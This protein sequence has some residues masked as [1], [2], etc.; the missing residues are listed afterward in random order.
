MC[1][2]NNY[3]QRS[4]LQS[5]YI[6]GFQIHNDHSWPFKDKARTLGINHWRQIAGYM[7]GLCLPIDIEVW[8]PCYLTNKMVKRFDFVVAFRICRPEPSI[9]LILG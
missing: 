5:A 3:K 9:S 6:M 7:G 1:F 4:R 2:K 8:D